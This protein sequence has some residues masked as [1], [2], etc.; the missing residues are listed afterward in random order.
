MV[1][2]MSVLSARLFQNC[3]EVLMNLHLSIPIL[4][5]RK[6]KSVKLGLFTRTLRKPKRQNDESKGKESGEKKNHKK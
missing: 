5:A 2:M 1:Q 6:E 3:P 4:E